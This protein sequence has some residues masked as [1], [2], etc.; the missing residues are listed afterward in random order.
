[1]KYTNKINIVAR[2]H[3][4]TI[5]YSKI[6]NNI[7]IKMLQNEFIINDNFSEDFIDFLIYKNWSELNINTLR[8]KF[9]NGK[10]ITTIFI[11]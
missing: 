11:K 7:Y 1:M 8:D 2:P 4:Y 6:D 5:Y 9:Y 3:S 10:K